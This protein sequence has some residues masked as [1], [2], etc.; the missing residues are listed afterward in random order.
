MRY[1]FRYIFSA[2]GLLAVILPVSAQKIETF[3]FGDMNQWITRNVTESVVIG[4]KQRH[5][6]AIGPT[7]TI[8]GDESLDDKGSP[9][10]TSNVVAKVSGVCKASNTVYPFPRNPGDTC[11]KLCT[12]IERVKVL[13]L[14]NVDVLV[15]GTIFLGKMVEPVSGVSQ[16]FEKMEMGIPFTDRPKSLVL[17]YKLD[18][19]LNDTRVRATGF[20]GKK[21]FSGHDSASVLV[22]LQRRWEDSDGTLHAARVGT[23]GELF[24]EGDQ[25]NDAHKV[26]IRYGDCSGVPEME[27]LGLRKDEDA[28]YARNSRGDLVPVHE[29]L[30]DKA[31]GKPTHM[32]VLISSGN[33]EPYEGTEGLTFYVDNIGLEY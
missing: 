6:Y 25:W 2:I 21:T 4:G 31:S 1:I 15:A 32:I 19:P 23:G 30:W 22:L 20:G 12:Q 24:S 33:G 8:D 13:G 11:A 16:P 14:I 3:E 29:E 5:L 9:W 26:K 7:E 17:D 27:W 10:R 28:F 18:M